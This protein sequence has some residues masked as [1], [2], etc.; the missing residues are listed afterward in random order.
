[1]TKFTAMVVSRTPYTR[2]FPGIDVVNS[3]QIFES[4]AEM[5]SARIALLDRAATPYCFY[6]DDDDDLPDDVLTV[7]EAC[8]ALGKALVYTDELVVTPGGSFVSSPGPYNQPAHLKDPTLVHHLAVM[9]TAAA[10]T[11]ALAVPPTNVLEMALY[12]Q[13]AKAGVAH[14]PQVGY[15]WNRRTGSLSSTDMVHQACLPT[16]QWC[17]AHK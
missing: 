10:R 11:A 3:V 15:I 16:V 5:M 7:L 14:M 2:T 12:W 6:L 4:C 1:M 13:L 17:G 8:S 9:D